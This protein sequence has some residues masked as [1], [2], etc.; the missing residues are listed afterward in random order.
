MATWADLKKQARDV[1]GLDLH[2]ADVT[3]I[4]M[5]ATDPYGNFT[6]G[7]HGLPQ[8]VTDSGLVEGDL[9]APVAVPADAVHFDT[10]FLTDIAH[11]ADPSPAD[12][13]HNPGTPPVAPDADDEHVADHDF[14]HQPAGHLRRRAARLALRRRRRPGQREHRPDR[15]PP[16]LP[17][18]ARPARRGHRQ[19][20]A[21]RHLRHRRRRAGV[22]E[23]DHRPVRLE[24]R[25]APV[26]GRPLRQRDGVPARRSSRSSR[27]RSSP[28]CSPSTS[29]SPTWTPP[30]RRSSR[31]RSTASATRC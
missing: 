13:D 10:P 20:P 21:G 19:D 25:T 30:S 14:T 8:Y 27:A 2:D 24:L 16:G 26:P 3:D 18:R 17:L 29:T 12:T 7:P 5:L 11:N 4:P 22:L 23:A 15:H 1:L 9:A 6:P 28:A 31:T